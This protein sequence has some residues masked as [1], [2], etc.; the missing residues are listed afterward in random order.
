[1]FS[2]HAGGAQVAMCDG[3]VHFISQAV[4]DAVLL[5]LASKDHGETVGISP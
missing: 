1:L 3:S 2:D 4:K 5:G